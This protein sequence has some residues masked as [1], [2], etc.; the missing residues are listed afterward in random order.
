VLLAG[1]QTRL[2]PR[3]TRA[4]IHLPLMLNVVIGRGILDLFRPMHVP[5]SASTERHGAENKIVSAAPAPSQS[6]ENFR[7]SYCRCFQVTESAFATSVFYKTAFAHFK[8]VAAVLLRFF[9]GLFREDFEMIRSLGET[10]TAAEFIRELNSF[11]YQRIRGR[12]TLRLRVSG[13]RLLDLRAQL[14][15]PEN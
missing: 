10:K 13:R 9:P 7:M 8:P 5:P 4:R 15:P 12:D 11:R 1:S 14:D 2:E 6:E 3:K